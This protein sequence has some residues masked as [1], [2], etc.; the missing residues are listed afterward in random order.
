MRRFS[1]TLVVGSLAS[2]C[3]FAALLVPGSAAAT[4]ARPIA[5]AAHT[6]PS[7]TVN[8]PMIRVGRVRPGYG[9][10]LGGSVQQ[11][12]NWAGY[13]A[14]G[15]GFRSVTASWTQPSVL[16]INSENAASS[17]WVGLDGDG[18]SSV[19]QCGTE[20]DDEFGTVTYSAWYEMYPAPETVIPEMTITPGDTMT[21]S[22]T[23]DGAGDFTLTLIDD[24][25]GV[26]KTVSEYGSDAT[27]YSAE[28]IAEAP[29]DAATGVQWPLADFGTRTSQTARSTTSRL[30]TPPGGRSTWST[31]QATRPWRRPRRLAQTGP[32][33]RLLV[34]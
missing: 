10:L 15:G 2:L 23:T 6:L 4:K 22:V 30:P 28:V 11:S 33:S 8:A 25:T 34:T 29:T 21:A 32:A 18:S 12:G 26:S 9:P 1:G 16:A 17:Y 31:N 14:I 24:T 20:A 13:D 3:V 27:G 5:L 7:S 19:E